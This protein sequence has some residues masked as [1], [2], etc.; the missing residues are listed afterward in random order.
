[1]TV[2]FHLAAVIEKLKILYFSPAS[3]LVRVFKH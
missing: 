3:L 2:T 1:M